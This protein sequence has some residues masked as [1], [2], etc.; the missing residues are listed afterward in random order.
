MAY[1]GKMKNFNAVKGF[2]FAV[3]DDGQEDFI[4]I[5]A[6]VDGMQPQQGDV[7]TYDLVA[8]ENKKGDKQ[9]ANVTGGTAQ[10]TRG[11][12]TATPV[13]G[14]GAHH[15][16]V[17]RFNPTKQYGFIDYNGTDIFFHLSSCVGTMAVEGDSVQFDMKDGKDG[18]ASNAVNVTG[19]TAHLPKETGKGKDGK[20]GPYGGWDAWGSP[21]GWGGG[22]A[23]G[24]CGG[25]GKGKGGGWGMDAWGGKGKGGKGKG[26]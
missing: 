16:T 3:R 13:Q 25:W 2:G 7:V 14:T 26:W 4:H 8:S 9:A 23:W 12:G 15:G 19:G 24:G 6:C 18:K 20:G 10:P 17:K 1:S 22:D 21:F 5:K 11:G